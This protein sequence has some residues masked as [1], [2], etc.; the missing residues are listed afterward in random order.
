MISGIDVSCPQLR[1]RSTRPMDKKREK[2]SPAD[3]DE[4]F[5]G[6]RSSSTNKAS[7]IVPHKFGTVMKVDSTCKEDLVKS[8]GH[9]Q[10]KNPIKSLLAQRT[11]S[12]YFHVLM[13]V[14]SGSLPI[15]YSLENVYQLPTILCKEEFMEVLSL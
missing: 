12:Q 8:W 14:V 3:L 11:T 1:L 2:V 9:L 7:R 10:K 6:M 4:W 15:S 13:H 5:P